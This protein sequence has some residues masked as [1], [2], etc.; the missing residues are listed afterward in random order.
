M[1]V[2][3]EF[4]KVEVNPD[5]HK[6]FSIYMHSRPMVGDI[7]WLSNSQERLSMR[8]DTVCHTVAKNV[9]YHSIAVYASEMEEGE[10]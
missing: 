5:S 6:G 8:V 10:E 7:L 1:T 2:T 4:M 3:S 9:E